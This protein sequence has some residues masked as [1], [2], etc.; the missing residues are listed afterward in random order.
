MYLIIHKSYLLTRL[1]RRQPDVRTAIT[2]ERIT[3][4]AV[5]ARAD[6]A[7]HREVYLGQ[8]VCVQL[9]EI[10]IGVGALRFVFGVDPLSKAAGAVFA[11]S[12][13]LGVRFA[14]FGWLWC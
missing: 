9:G 1:E 8:V 11:G 13:P 6:L 4:R 5:P 12:A 14:G 2:P 10:R 7:L 3:Q